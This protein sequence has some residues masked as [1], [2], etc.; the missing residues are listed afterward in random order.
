M[1]IEQAY[2]VILNVNFAYGRQ[3]TSRLIA[4]LEI[5]ILTVIQGNWNGGGHFWQIG[6]PH[7]Q[8]TSTITISRF[9]TE[10]D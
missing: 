1:H 8:L 4:V 9:Y 10:M 3:I 2:A 5:A 6:R 7:D